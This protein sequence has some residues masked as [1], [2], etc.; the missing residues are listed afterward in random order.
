[1]L[2]ITQNEY[3]LAS[4][5]RFDALRKGD[6]NGANS[7]LQPPL[8]VIEHNINTQYDAIPEN[9]FDLP[10]DPARIVPTAFGNAY[11]LA[12]EYAY[13][14]YRIDTVLFWSRLRAAMH[15]HAA[16][17]SD[18][19]T[20]QK[21]SLDLTLNLSFVSL[22]IAVEC[23]LTLR[24]GAQGYD[25][26][27]LLLCLL[28]ALLFVG[29]YSSSVSAVRILAELIMM[30]FDLY[31]HLILETFHIQKPDDLRLERMLWVQL[32]A[33]LRRGD[34]FYFPDDI[35]AHQSEHL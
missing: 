1:M 30:S 32:A 27:L 4:V 18:H 16:I 31:R 33:F 17:H 9:R 14:R 13:D 21:T 6:P 29:F 20:H 26:G 23:A 34:P 24:A 12:E 7:Q 15:E 3:W 2:R 8:G 19:L 28:S 10:R 22:L 35:A 5:A 11:A 25:G